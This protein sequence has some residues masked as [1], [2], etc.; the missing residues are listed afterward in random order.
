MLREAGIPARYATGYAVIER[1]A[2]RGGHRHP[3]HPRPRLVPRL[4]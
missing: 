4:G 3:R 2:K 1:D